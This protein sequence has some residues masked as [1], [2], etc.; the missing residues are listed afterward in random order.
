MG[1]NSKESLINTIQNLSKAIELKDQQMDKL[2]N[3]YESKSMEYDALKAKWDGIWGF[4][5][6]KYKENADKIN[7]IN[8]DLNEY[9]NQRNKTS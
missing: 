4:L 8:K 7:L 6:N 5:D 1:E 2:L 9:K 3:L